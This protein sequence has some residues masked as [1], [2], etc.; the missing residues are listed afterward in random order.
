MGASGFGFPHA[1]A[2]QNRVLKLQ[3]LEFEPTKVH[4]KYPRF[5]SMAEI[6]HSHPKAAQ[7]GRVC[8]TLV[9]Y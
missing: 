4:C 1:E 5:I 3:I 7:E 8:F 2:V 6:K 9:H